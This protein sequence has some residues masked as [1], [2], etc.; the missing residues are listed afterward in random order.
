[1][2]SNLA[3]LPDCADV[4]VPFGM[5]K[6]SYI[7][8]ACNLDYKRLS[9]HQYCGDIDNWTTT[10]FIT[11]LNGTQG[12]YCYKD[13]TKSLCY[14]GE[15]HFN[16]YKFDGA[17]ICTLKVEDNGQIH[18]RA[19]CVYHINAVFVVGT[20]D[21]AVL[22]YDLDQNKLVKYANMYQQSKLCSF[23]MVKDSTGECLLLFGGMDCDSLEMTNTIIQFN[24]T[25]REW[26]KSTAKLPQKMMS[27]HCTLA[28][29]NKYVL[30]FGGAYGGYNSYS[31]DIYVYSIQEQT[32][33]E[34]KL[35]CPSKSTFTGITVSDTKQ[36]QKT[37][38]GFVRK[39]WKLCELQDEYFPPFCLLEIIR[40]YY[41][42]EYVCLLDV[43]SRKHYKLNTLE[44]V[45]NTKEKHNSPNKKRKISGA[46]SKDIFILE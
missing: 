14:I 44:I 6:T 37:V 38:V 17:N 26:V 29:R 20:G 25:T 12:L 22:K 15:G 23:G 45:D 13:K 18:C 21:R 5:D 27:I 9:L 43:Q 2:S 7:V 1:M 46:I 8:I 42:T 16:E 11:P 24:L 39:E 34:S 19:H 41:F 33:K 28:I 40:T 4:C 35:K 3:A 31:D 36:D 30:A 32:L 10:P